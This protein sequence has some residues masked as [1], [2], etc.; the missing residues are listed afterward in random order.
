MAT[1]RSKL[2][3]QRFK[4]R[5]LN[6][7]GDDAAFLV[8]VVDEVE[9]EDGRSVAAASTTAS[10]KKYDILVSTRAPHT[11]KEEKEKRTRR[12][13]QVFGFSRQQQAQKAGLLNDVS[14]MIMRPERPF[15]EDTEGVVLESTR[16]QLPPVPATKEKE[17]SMVLSLSLSLPLPL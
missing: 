11:K 17:G 3:P 15:N 6:Y 5:I 12:T 13:S 8:R 7:S 10:G 2:N 9:E 16:E 1:L 4:Q 14:R